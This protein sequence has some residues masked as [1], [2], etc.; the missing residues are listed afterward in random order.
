MAQRILVLDD[1]ENY[2]DMLR[3][4]LEQH[5]FLVDSVTDPARALEKLHGTGYELVISDFK[6]P[7]MD[8][9]DFLSK[10]REMNPDLPVIL[11]SGLMNTP[12]LVKVANMGVTLVLEKPI[13]IQLFINH[14]K[15]F[16]QPATKDEF[17]VHRQGKSGEVA[18]ALA[19]KQTYPRTL[20][21]LCDRSHVFRYFLEH[22]WGAANEQ[23]HI[24]ISAPRG[25]EA[26]LL[27][28]EVSLWRK[29]SATRIHWLDL[30]HPDCVRMSAA[31]KEKAVDSKTSELVG[32]IGFADSSLA[33]QEQVVDCIRESPENLA[34]LYFIESDLIDSDTRVIDPE[35]RELLEQS[36]CVMPPLNARLADLAAYVKRYLPL[37]AESLKR[38]GRSELDPQG[39]A[40]LLS[41]TWPGNFRELI[42]VLRVAVALQ[43]EGPVMQQDL[44]TALQRVSNHNSSSPHELLPL[45]AAIQERQHYIVSNAMRESGQDIVSTLNTLG[46]GPQAIN[47]D[48][49]ADN[50]PLIYPELIN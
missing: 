39:I 4:L 50:L 45:S 8:G 38:P 20:H 17:R 31:L 34:F 5:S 21:Y 32:V 14:V 43:T 10:S 29:F 23:D 33:A 28:R 25:S 27:L 26:D 6:M 12:D 47:P 11:V 46:V 16:V 44:A 37:I 35:L 24:F 22:V 2:A 40:L 15:R 9:A 19:F 1:E 18:G 13:D 49:G 48:T 36:L 30:R 3:A 41:Y 42:D 7:G